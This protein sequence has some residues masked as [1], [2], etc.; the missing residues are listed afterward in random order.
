MFDPRENPTVFQFD[1][2]FKEGDKS[3]FMAQSITYGAKVGS[4]EQLEVHWK[5]ILN[6]APGEKIVGAKVDSD[7][8]YINSI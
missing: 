8:F 1:I 5:Q 2:H 7:D 4:N 3:K 6:L